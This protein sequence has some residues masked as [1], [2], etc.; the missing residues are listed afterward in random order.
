MSV[1]DVEIKSLLC[2]TVLMSAAVVVVLVQSLG[3]ARYEVPVIRGAG[4]AV[5]SEGMKLG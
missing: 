2:G 5:T 1:D 4:G 3:A